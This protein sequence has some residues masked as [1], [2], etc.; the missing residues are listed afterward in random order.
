METDV[1][2][3]YSIHYTKLYD[4]NNGII[5]LLIDKHHT[6]WVATSGGGVNRFNEAGHN[7]VR[8]DSK[9]SGLKNDFISNIRESQYGYLI[10]T[11][12]HGFSIL[13]AENNK[14]FNYGIENGLPLN[15]YNFV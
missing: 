7:F 1:I 5:K 2:T 9:H 3:S 14:T 8:Y 15:S 10:V 11:T 4:A 12:T 6:M 13:D